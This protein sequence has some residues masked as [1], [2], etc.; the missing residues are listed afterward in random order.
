MFVVPVRQESAE[1]FPPAGLTLDLVTCSTHMV[2]HVET[3]DMDQRNARIEQD[4]G[5]PQVLFQVELPGGGP[6]KRVAPKPNDH[7]AVD[8]LRGQQKSAA[9]IRRCTDG[10]NI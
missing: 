6:I 7:D 4:P 8:D 2:S 1:L 5:R 9:D 3:R 10:D